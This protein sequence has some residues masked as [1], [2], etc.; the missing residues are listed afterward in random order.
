M[1]SLL[2]LMLAVQNVPNATVVERALAQLEISNGRRTLSGHSG[3]D[4]DHS[5]QRG[6]I[7]KAVA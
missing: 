3:D 7:T 6:T 4:G 2:I 5:R 1:I